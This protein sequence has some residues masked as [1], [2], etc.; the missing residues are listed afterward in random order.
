MLQ[1]QTFE[2]VFQGEEPA[3]SWTE[4]DL[5]GT[6]ICQGIKKEVDGFYAGEGKYMV[7]YLPQETGNV[8]WKVTG[9]FNEEGEEECVSCDDGIHH[10]L[11]KPDGTALRFEDGTLCRPFGTTV[12]AMMHQPEELIR[13]TV[14]TMLASPFDKIRTCVFP[15]HYIFNENEPERFA[16]EKK[17]EGGF[18]FHRPD[19]RFWDAFEKVIRIFDMHQIQ[20][21]L[22]LFH[23]YDC[24]GFSE[25]KEEEYLPY[26]HYLIA[27]FSAFPNIW[28]SLAN[29]YD[30]M[31]AFTRE[32]WDRID[33]FVSEK[34]VYGHM[35]SC[36]H[37]I[38][39]YDFSKKNI[40]H[41][42]LQGDAATVEK[43]MKLF[44]KPVLI[45]ECGYEGNIF[46]H[47]GHLSGFEMVNRI[48]H[49]VVM[50]GYC[51][52]GETFMHPEDILWWG[53][54]GKLYGE[55]PER[56]RFLK[57]II[58]ELPGP[59]TPVPSTFLSLEKLEEMKKGLHPEEVTD[60]VRAVMDMPKEEAERVIEDITKDTRIFTGHC[61]EDAFLAYYGRHC[62]AVG[63]LELP[64]TGT[65]RVEV[66]DVWE[67]TRKTIF[68]G[69]NGTV[70]LSLPGKEGIAVLAVKTGMSAA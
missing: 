7:R 48:W 21:D 68:T 62:T 1:Y 24:W 50:G 36:H 52:H 20:V 17:E 10:G 11:V 37:M 35:L 59:L 45:D 58:H 6:F 51:T 56:I 69:V 15:K 12:Y 9:L 19:F 5:R 18:D 43:Y 2:L 28:W 67:M 57:N 61:G 39:H 49:C 46:C 42:S 66:I 3:G 54:G 27:R 41:C 70:D 4:V 26:L 65:Y 8:R 38:R 34:D 47:W 33:S 23:P 64:E 55:S 31:R 30:C 13:Q 53:K 44:H 32:D 16:F 60:F 63:S 40:T 14:E 22:I 25:M 29:E